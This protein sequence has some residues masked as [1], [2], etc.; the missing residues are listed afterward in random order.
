MRAG[1]LADLR[2]AA[3]A[4]RGC[5]PDERALFIEAWLVLLWYWLRWRAGFHG[6]L[7]R[8]DLA[9]HA[10][11]TQADAPSPQARRVLAAFRKAVH[12]HVVRASCVPRSLA[13]QRLLQ[14]RGWM[15]SI[16]VGVRRSGGA[17]EG[18]AWVESDQIPQDAH[19]GVAAPFVACRSH[20]IGVV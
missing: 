18:H 2:R 6:T 11:P 4:W 19:A 3:H 10:A 7:L 8:S 13:L 5:P 17:I 12:N 16:H 20:Q 15:A 14:R 1:V 9:R